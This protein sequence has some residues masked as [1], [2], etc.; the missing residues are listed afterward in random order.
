MAGELW[1]GSV[2]FGKE[3][4]ATYGTE[5][6][7][8]R[9]MY[10]R[11]PVLT[12]ERE[13]RIH[14]F[15]TGTRD[16]TRQITL[17]PELVGGTLVQPVSA[18]CLELLLLG[19]KGEVAAVGAQADKTY[20]FVP[21][22][23]ALNSATI[24]WNDGARVWTAL[25]MMVDTLKFAGSVSGESLL[26]ATLFGKSMSIKAG[27][28][29]L[30]HGTPAVFEGWESQLLID[31]AGTTPATTKTGVL[32]SWDVTI[33]NG[34]A[35]KFTAANTLAPS[36]IITNE[37]EV[38]ASLVVEASAAQVATEYAAWDAATEKTVGLRFGANAV[39]G[40]TAAKETVEIDIPGK[41]SAVDLGQTDEGTR[42][43][44]LTLN[45]VY[46]A[47]LTYGVQVVVTTARATAWAGRP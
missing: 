29:G 41:W 46:N 30:K 22:S 25:G 33:A 16:N 17:G 23:T 32:L 13:P 44:Q 2:A 31:A 34:L 21:G 36:A 35:R 15:M 39:I 37:I 12:R 10:F 38:T 27:T 19:L 42:A 6:D 20:T 28:A 3:A 45:Y 43:Y 47:T 26:T 5:V 11:D 18:E 24:E 4:T 7:A 8:T 1:S 14:K 40:A 9:I